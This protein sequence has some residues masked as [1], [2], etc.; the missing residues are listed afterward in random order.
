MTYA[1][2]TALGGCAPDARAS[3]S[4]LRC[5]PLRSSAAESELDN[6]HGP[7]TV[8][9]LHGYEPSVLHG[10]FAAL[11]AFFVW[12][13]WEIVGGIIGDI[14]VE[15]GWAATGPVRRPIWRAYV[16]ASWPW[17]LFLSLAIAFGII[18]GSLSL[19]EPGSN[20][21][22]FG[23]AVLDLIGGA[24]LALLAPL[25]WR[26]ARRQRLPGHERSC[27]PRWRAHHDPTG[28]QRGT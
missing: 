11:G 5:P 15:V 19:M 25:L 8:A 1:V 18:G 3:T 20:N 12:L 4:S 16:T 24:W 7:S 14:L 6:F 23:A 27:L 21:W 17:P 9:V 26:D 22:Q 10:L 2:A 13:V 28:K